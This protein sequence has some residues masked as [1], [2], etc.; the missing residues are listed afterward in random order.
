MVTA[1]HTSNPENNS[2]IDRILWQQI[3]RFMLFWSRYKARKAAIIGSENDPES[4]G[5]TI[6]RR[7]S[8]IG[9]PRKVKEAAISCFE[10]EP[11]DN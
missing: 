7:K 10:E 2:P 3:R 9:R 1:N 8:L 11:F 6:N 5:S 4:R